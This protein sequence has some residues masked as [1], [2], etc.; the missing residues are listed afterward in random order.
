[1]TE[2]RE[3]W[4]GKSPYHIGDLGPGESVD[5]PLTPEASQ[6]LRTMRLDFEQQLLEIDRQHRRRMWRTLA[7][8]GVW[9]V[10]LLINQFVWKSQ[11]MAT[12]LSISL[13]AWAIY[14]FAA[15]WR[16]F[17]DWP[18]VLFGL[19]VLLGCIALVT[20]DLMQY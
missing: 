2:P 5:I 7:I 19:L 3:P 1:M 10:L 8:F 18:L 13:L 20:I 14:H 12:A 6:R 17:R 16:H 11:P 15:A 9:W 4:D